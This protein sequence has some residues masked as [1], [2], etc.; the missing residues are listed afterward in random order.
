ML[1]L[2][3]DNSGKIVY[4]VAKMATL[5]RRRYPPMNKIF[6]NIDPKQFGEILKTLR[7]S[8]N[9][10][11]GEV[12]DFLGIDRSTYTKY[13]LGKIPDV[14]VIA[15]LSA[16]YNVSTDGILSVFFEEDNSGSHTAV[17]NAVDEK[18]SL[19]L[20]SEDESRL[21]EAYRLC[22]NKDSIVDFAQAV[23][24]EET[25]YDMPDATDE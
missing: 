5:L 17:L 10:S 25:T 6:R 14:S 2:Y 24:L 13:E 19:Y 9:L 22:L 21:I 1:N 20:L 3:F 18:N 12:A 8:K 15:R 23:Y 16:Y 7:K 11:Q 4:N